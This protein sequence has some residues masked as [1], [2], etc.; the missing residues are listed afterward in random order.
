MKNIKKYLHIIIIISFSLILSFLLYLTS[1]LP[2]KEQPKNDFDNYLDS[3]WDNKQFYLP[4]KMFS[5]YDTYEQFYNLNKWLYAQYENLNE[6]FNSDYLI[7]K[8][9]LEDSVSQYDSISNGKDYLLKELKT[10]PS[11]IYVPKI[12]QMSSYKFIKNK[13]NIINYYTNNIDDIITTG[14]YFI[15]KDYNNFVN[16]IIEIEFSHED[17]DTYVIPILTKTYWTLCPDK[18]NKGIISLIEECK[19][20]YYYQA[21]AKLTK[22]KKFLI[23]IDQLRSYESLINSTLEYVDNKEI[24]FKD[25]PHAEMPIYEIEETALGPADDIEYCLDY[26]AFEPYRQWKTYIW[27]GDNGNVIV[28]AR[29]RNAHIRGGYDPYVSDV[30]FWGEYSK[31]QEQEKELEEKLL[32]EHSNDNIGWQD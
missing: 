2:V 3:Y 15:E 23:F 26:Y 8:L 11:Q 12:I 24:E 20:L 17:D 4:N 19:D 5:D 7:S 18:I 10:I 22:L 9:N 32:K 16:K 25:L 28:E 30:T 14:Y 29:V 27:Y 6:E 31:F 21:E 1:N 13:T